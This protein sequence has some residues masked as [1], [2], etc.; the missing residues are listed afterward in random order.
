[1]DKISTKKLVQKAKKGDGQAFVHLCQ[2]YETVLYNAAYKMLLNEV[3]V[4]DCLQETELC[5]WEKITTLKNEYAFNSWI[6]KIML[7]QVQNIFREKQKTTHWM[8]TYS[9]VPAFDDLY[10]LDKG[11]HKLPDNYRVPLVM[12]Y[13][14]GLSIKEIAQQLDVSKKMP[15]ETVERLNTQ[16]TKILMGEIKQYR[17]P[18]KK[19]SRKHLIIGLISIA[20]TFTL[21]VKT[22][23]G[24]AIEEVLGISQDTGVQT[25]ESSGVPTK[26]E[27]RSVQNEREIV[28]TKFVST[29]NKM[30][31][32]YQFKI[33]DQKLK[34]LLQKKI[35][36]N[37]YS[38]DIQ[39]GL[40]R[41]GSKEDLFGGVSSTSLYRIEKD[42]FYGSVISTFNK[43]KLVS[44]D[45]L[46]LHIYRLALE[47][48]EQHDN[49][50]KEAIKASSRSFSVENALEYQGDWTFKIPYQPIMKETIPSIKNVK[51]IKNIKAQ[52]DAL[53]T[54]LIMDIPNPEKNK[55]SRDILISVYKNGLEIPIARQI[56]SGFNKG[57]DATINISFDLSSLDHKSLYKVIVRNSYEDDAAGKEL[58]SLELK[59][60]QK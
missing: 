53:Q 35:A 2:K 8:D 41:E 37:N 55:K 15:L 29:K 1:M 36:R 16:R 26:L 9:P 56:G 31:F 13:Y 33:K 21:I 28:L 46:T 47:D 40:F 30:A 3:D 17:Q 43:Q 60:T 10:D 25:V 22:P 5:A 34:E 23:I 45:Q 57:E 12:Y 4:A 48:Q 19:I 59:N 42:V 14:V 24:R 49:E 54:T 50:L 52:S 11:L 18:K 58:G 32:D 51:K 27:L 44:Q 38:Q 20:T 6:F 7:N 39:L